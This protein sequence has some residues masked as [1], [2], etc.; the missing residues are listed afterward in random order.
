[1]TG[2]AQDSTTAKPLIRNKDPFFLSSTKEISLGF[3]RR[4]HNSGVMSGR[5]ALRV[6]DDALWSARGGR[7]GESGNDSSGGFRGC[8][9]RRVRTELCKYYYSRFVRV[10]TKW[11]VARG[12]IPHNC[13]DGY[14]PEY[15]FGFQDVT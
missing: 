10:I 1:M 14:Q 3:P 5:L 4:W 8:A 12:M 2:I 9:G 6:V 15:N 7:F 11:R 13:I